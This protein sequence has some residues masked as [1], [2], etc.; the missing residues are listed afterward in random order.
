VVTPQ[1]LHP[2]RVSKGRALRAALGSGSSSHGGPT[3]AA[4]GHLLDGYDLVFALGDDRADDDIFDAIERS[5]SHAFTCTL[6]TRKLSRAAY[7]LDADEVLPTLQTLAAV[8][9]HDKLL[10][11]SS[12]SAA[13]SAVPPPPPLTPQTSHTGAMSPSSAR[14]PVAA[15]VETTVVA[16]ATPAP[17]PEL[18]GGLSSPR[19]TGDHSAAFTP[20]V[21]SAEGGAG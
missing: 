4:A 18:L 2:S 6:G 17:A 13:T 3:R 9:E 16:P 19:T 5:S 8:S 7:S 21:A 10:A 11:L 20:P 12:S 15:A 14:A 1:V